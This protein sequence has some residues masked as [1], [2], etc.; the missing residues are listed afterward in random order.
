MR[1]ED[2]VRQRLGFRDL[3]RTVVLDTL[4]RMESKLATFLSQC[5]FR[6]V[7]QGDDSVNGSAA[8][9]SMNNGSSAVEFIAV[10]SMKA[11]EAGRT[12][13]NREIASGWPRKGG[14]GLELDL[15]DPRMH[16]RLPGEMRTGLPN[17]GFV[18]YS[19][20]QAVVRRLA[21]VAAEVE[22]NG[23]ARTRVA[24]LALYAAQAELIRRLL[25]GTELPF[26]SDVEIEVDVASSFRQREADIVLLSLT[27]SHSHRPVAFGENPYSLALALTRARSKLLL[28]GDPG[29][30]MR[31][32]QWQGPLEHLNEAAA[33]Q[34]RDLIVRLVRHLQSLADDKRN[35]PAAQRNP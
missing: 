14:A 22:R 25:L 17:H 19:E 6:G 11:A 2:W 3:G 8:C 18:N 28:F 30:L 33:D 1:A 12:G 23:Q 7:E 21:S 20:G 13:S 27:R 15:G 9:A 5:V 10:P 29:T 35:S 24:V 34:E 32:S 31:R 26:P 4:H 16:D